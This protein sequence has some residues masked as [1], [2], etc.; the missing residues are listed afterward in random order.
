MKARA[1]VNDIY[2]VGIRDW[3]MRDFHGFATPGV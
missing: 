1:V 3:T 2:E